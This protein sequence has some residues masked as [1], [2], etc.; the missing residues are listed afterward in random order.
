MLRECSRGLRFRTS[1][2]NMQCLK[3]AANLQLPNVA[4]SATYR[5]VLYSHCVKVYHGCYYY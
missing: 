5:T 4:Q 3:A 1:D 2:L